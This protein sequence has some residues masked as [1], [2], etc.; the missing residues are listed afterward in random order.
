MPSA[1]PGEIELAAG[2]PLA[3][4]VQSRIAPTTTSTAMGTLT[5]NT[6]RQPVPG[7]HSAERDAEGRGQRN[8]RA[9]DAER[10]DPLALGW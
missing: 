2:G 3:V 1:A 9:P 8:G 7:K 10:L 5:R 6:A 4:V